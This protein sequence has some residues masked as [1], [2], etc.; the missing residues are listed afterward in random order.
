ME[1]SLDSSIHQC[2]LCGG[3]GLLKENLGLPTTSSL[4]LFCWGLT[5]YFNHFISE[6]PSPGLQEN[7]AFS[8]F[9]FIKSL[10]CSY[11]LNFALFRIHATLHFL[12]VQFF[13]T[14][15][16]LPSTSIKEL[17]QNYQITSNK[18]QK[19]AYNRER[20]GNKWELLQ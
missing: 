18:Q 16:I 17:T 19:N 11:I 13:T 12:I 3:D 10:H 4:F 15:S 20:S 2:I 14:F 6:A 5:F 9:I 8:G 1:Y 7:L